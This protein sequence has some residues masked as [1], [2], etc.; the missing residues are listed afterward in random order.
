VAE[1]LKREEFT[2]HEIK[3]EPQKF[4]KVARVDEQDYERLSAYTWYASVDHPNYCYVFRWITD[5]RIAYRCSL[6]EDVLQIKRTKDRII[7]HINRDPLDNHKENLRTCTIQ[8]KGWN[9]RTRDNK[10][11]SKYKCVTYMR[12]MRYGRTYKRN[13]PVAK[14]WRVNIYCNKKRQFSAAFDDEYKAYLKCQEKLKELHGEFACLV[15]WSGYSNQRYPNKP[16][17]YDSASP[18]FSPGFARNN[19]TCVVGGC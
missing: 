9:R 7:D 4:G 12:Y 13:K 16:M 3:L 19:T 10:I 6:H 8:Q 18:H 17:N 15:P 2:R 11:S 14:P 5:H 1:N